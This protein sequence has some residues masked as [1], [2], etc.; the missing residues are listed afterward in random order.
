[1]K[2]KIQMFIDTA[3][4]YCYVAIYNLNEKIDEIKIKVNKNVTDI[5]VENI[6]LLLEKNKFDYKNINELYL[7]VGPGSF[8]GVRVGTL[9]AKAWL[10][11]Y[12]MTKI[13]IINSLLLQITNKNSISVIDAKS[14]KSYIAIYKN[15]KE[16]LKPTIFLNTELE[17]IISNYKDAATVC[18][19]TDES[20]D[21]F[22]LHKKHFKLINTKDLQPLYI[23]LPL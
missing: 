8:T 11:L 20:Y 14:D 4:N 12:K 9:I 21:N 23:K 15:N 18:N 17:K 6:K 1:M 2:N 3:N 7:N 5:I 16:I 22:L 13:F 19:K 10:N